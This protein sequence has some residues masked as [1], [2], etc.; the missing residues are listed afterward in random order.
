[1]KQRVNQSLKGH[2]QSELDTLFAAIDILETS[3]TTKKP[4]V[5][6][7]IVH[8]YQARWLVHLILEHAL[9]FPSLAEVLLYEADEQLKQAIAL[10]TTKSNALLCLECNGVIQLLYARI[11]DGKVSW[12]LC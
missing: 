8:F 10:D 5:E 1:M 7:A 9:D 12:H 3:I 4:Q 2:E 6:T 11:G